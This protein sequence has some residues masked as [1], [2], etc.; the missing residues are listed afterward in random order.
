MNKNLK[1]AIIDTDKSFIKALSQRLKSWDI[2]C[3][4]TTSGASFFQIASQSKPDIIML[5]DDLKSPSW[6]EVLKR[7]KQSN[8]FE[9]STIFIICSKITTG[10]IHQAK[11]YDIQHIIQ[12]PITFSDFIKRIQKEFQ[13]NNQNYE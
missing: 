4:G 5:A 2:A 7:I 3:T 9:H 13:K 12:K 1:I 8:S 10:L 6:T 11:L